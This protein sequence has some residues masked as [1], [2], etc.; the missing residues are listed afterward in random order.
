MDAYQLIIMA[1]II[2]CAVSSSVTA[3]KPAQPSRCIVDIDVNDEVFMRPKPMTQQD[4]KIL[5]TDLKDNGCDTILVRMG[6]L[7]L[8]PYR[9]KLSYPVA[10]DEALGREKGKDEPCI[11][12][13]EKSIAQE[14]PWCDRYAQVIKDFNPPAAFVKYGHE[15]GLKV[16][17]W[18]DIFD[19]GFPGF[20]SKFIE[21]HPW[22]QWTGKDGKTYFPGLIS[23][24]W[25]EARAFR[26]AQAKELLDLGADGIHCS[27]SAHCRHLRNVHEI[28]YY[29]YEKPVVD[30]YKK[31]YKVDIRTAPDFDREAWHNIKG[32][33]M[34]LLYA[35]LARVCHRRGKELWIGLQI[36]K[37]T[38]MPSDGYFGT[39]V[40]VR[41]SNHWKKLVDK[42][43]ADAFVLGDYEQMS[44]GKSNVYWSSKPDIVVR[45]HEDLFSWAAREYSPYCGS[46]T[47][48][49]LFGEWLF[50]DRI[51]L[52]KTF[53]DWANRVNN[54][55]FDGIDIH[56]A[57]NIEGPSS[58]ELFK[59]FSTRLKGID[60]GP[61]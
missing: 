61:L 11:E 58:L 16:I 60:P 5:L 45:G 20:R 44:L 13:M 35:D 17:F 15:A 59:R 9:T 2:T 56:E 57:S 25:P 39:N 43:I 54:Y 21:E 33:M 24:A 41:Y 47:K 19:D 14:K 30:E 48:L 22:C 55:N 27:T 32:D 8:L 4:V 36:G 46:K 7:G 12:D 6:F 23:Y 52:D 18:L 3:A 34:D 50:G 42:G 26:V 37:H 10:F 53:E 28:D 49:Y 51:K 38:I 29:G 1:G 31:R 40:V